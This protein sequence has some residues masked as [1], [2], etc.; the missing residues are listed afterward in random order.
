M[1]HVQ[2]LK[3]CRRGRYWAAGS[4]HARGALL[5]AA[6]PT[7]LPLPAPAAS[8]TANVDV[9]KGGSGGLEDSKGPEDLQLDE[10]NGS[11]NIKGPQESNGPLEPNGS[12]QSNGPEEP[13]GLQQAAQLARRAT[14]PTAA[15]TYWRALFLEDVAGVMQ[16]EASVTHLPAG[17]MQQEGRVVGVG[18]GEVPMAAGQQGGVA[19]VEAAGKGGVRGGGVVLAPFPPTAYYFMHSAEEA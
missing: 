15:D 14:P 3:R 12:Q 10:S 19:V 7:A 11:Q 6:A 5:P 17:V 9:A 16:Q 13:K 2:L 4:T 8:A 1:L 18:G